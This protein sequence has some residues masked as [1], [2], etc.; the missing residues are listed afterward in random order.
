M[1]ATAWQPVE[2]P[3]S[4]DAEQLG[5]AFAQMSVALADMARRCADVATTLHDVT[6]QDRA[7]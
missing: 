3:Q 6:R 7:A 2:R 4:V 1:R 5:R